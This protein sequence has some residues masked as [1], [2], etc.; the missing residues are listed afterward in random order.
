MAVRKSLK[1]G[2]GSASKAVAQLKS[3]KLD[4]LEYFDKS[5]KSDLAYVEYVTDLSLIDGKV[6]DGTSEERR[7]TF[8]R[9]LRRAIKSNIATDSPEFDWGQTQRGGD[10]ILPYAI[11]AS[12]DE[13]S[14]KVT[15][16]KLVL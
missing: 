13:K 5:R 7:K 3:R 1:S 14:G 8:R 6:L 10:Y 15:I 11:R 12:L 9:S 4:T 16:T 2:S